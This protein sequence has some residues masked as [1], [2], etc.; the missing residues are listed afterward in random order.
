MKLSNSHV[1]DFITSFVKF[2]GQCKGLEASERLYLHVISRGLINKTLIF[3]QVLS[4]SRVMS[5]F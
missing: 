2:K 3:F 5:S 4:V 1:H